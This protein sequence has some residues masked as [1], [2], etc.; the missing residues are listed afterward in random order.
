MVLEWSWARAAPARGD[1][2]SAIAVN[3]GDWCRPGGKNSCIY[4]LLVSEVHRMALDKAWLSFEDT[5]CIFFFF[6]SFFPLEA[7][8]K[9]V[10]N[11]HTISSEQSG[12][13][14]REINQCSQMKTYFNLLCNLKQQNTSA[15]A[16]PTFY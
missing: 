6:F 14:D 9:V 15:S 5:E 2:C 13:T 3:W 16:A 8:W 4:H 7:L 12:V 11:T 1:G 10:S